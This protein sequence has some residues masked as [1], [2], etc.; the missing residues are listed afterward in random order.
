MKEFFQKVFSEPTGQPS[1]GRVAFGFVILIVMICVLF[2]VIYNRPV[3]TLSEWGIFIATVGGVTY[4][5][6]KLGAVFGSKIEA[7]GDK[8]ASSP[9]P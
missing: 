7:E 4:G 6:S 5:T 9:T 3:L 2:L 1:F 8:P